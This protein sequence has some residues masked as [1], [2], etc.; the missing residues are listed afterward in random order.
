MK[1]LHVSAKMKSR[2][3]FYI[4][5]FIYLF[6]F[7][8]VFD[9]LSSQKNVCCAC[10]VIC[11]SI[12]MYADTFLFPPHPLETLYPTQMKTPRSI[13]NCH[14]AFPTTLPPLLIL[15]S[16]LNWLDFCR[17]SKSHTVYTNPLG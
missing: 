3:L 9:V 12:L 1:P 2:L 4:P 16:D 10:I 8:L 17:D 15:I 13:Q 11:N 7:F 14:L 6:F 5:T